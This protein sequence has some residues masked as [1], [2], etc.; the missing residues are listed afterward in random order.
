MG[1]QQEMHSVSIVTTWQPSLLPPRSP[2]VLILNN[3]SEQQGLKP[4][5]SLVNYLDRKLYSATRLLSTIKETR[6][7][8]VA[9]SISQMYHLPSLMAEYF[10]NAPSGRWVPPPFSRGAAPPPASPTLG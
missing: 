7:L 1:C 4:L 9:A 3:G 6:L 10:W 5:K 2:A 8:S